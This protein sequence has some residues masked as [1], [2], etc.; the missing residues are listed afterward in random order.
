MLIRGANSSSHP[1]DVSS[2]RLYTLSFALQRRLVH[3]SFNQPLLYVCKQALHRLI[4]GGR[5][6]LWSW[7]SYWV[8]CRNA[9]TRH[10]I[11]YKMHIHARHMYYC[12]LLAH[13]LCMHDRP[14]DHAQTLIFIGEWVVGLGRSMGVARVGLQ[15]TLSSVHLHSTTVM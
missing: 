13:V 9:Y 10:N 2:V 3:W 4:T 15:S 1:T 5:G 12:V 7:V 14:R 8:T 11:A 6:W